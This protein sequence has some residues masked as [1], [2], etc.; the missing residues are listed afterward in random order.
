MS[1]SMAV[2]LTALASGLL[3]GFINV[4]VVARAR[5]RFEGEVNTLLEAHGTDIKELKISRSD[6]WKQINENTSDISY[7][8]GKTNGKARM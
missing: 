8:Q 4:A 3:T 5:G 6:M 7:L 1:Q 2:I